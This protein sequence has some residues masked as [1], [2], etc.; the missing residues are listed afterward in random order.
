MFPK[1]LSLSFQKYNYT[2]VEFT[3][4]K[5]YYRAFVLLLIM[6]NNMAYESITAAEANFTTRYNQLRGNL[7]NEWEDFTGTL[8]EANAGRFAEPLRN[9]PLVNGNFA[10]AGGNSNPTGTRFLYQR[11]DGNGN[12]IQSP[13]PRNGYSRG[14][15]YSDSTGVEAQLNNYQNNLSYEGTEHGNRAQAV[16]GDKAEYYMEAD[17]FL[18]G[19]LQAYNEGLFEEAY[20]LL[21]HANLDIDEAHDLLN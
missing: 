3:Y 20:D 1:A 21:D 9:I 14:Y 13:T 18:D 15:D 12:V 5:L 10:E 11:S 16:N 2:F 19:A 7:Q 6:R 4:K 17:Q 8:N